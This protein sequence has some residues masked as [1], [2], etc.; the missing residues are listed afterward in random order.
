LPEL[1]GGLD[2]RYKLHSVKAFFT[3]CDICLDPS[4]IVPY[5]YKI[6]VRLY[7]T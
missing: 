3:T 2:Y 4:I 7:E 6:V 5:V 1:D